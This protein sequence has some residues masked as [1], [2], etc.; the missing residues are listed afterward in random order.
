MKHHPEY[1][2]KAETWATDTQIL[3]LRS[4][5]TGWTVAA[6]AI[7][8][9]A[10]Q[11][12]ALAMLAPLK[13]VQP[14]TLLVDR[15]TGFVQAVDPDTPQRI[16]ADEA[17]TQSFLAQYVAA[18]EGF[19]RA[20]LALDYRKVALLSAGSAR[21]TYLSQMPATNPASPFRRFPSGAVVATRIK[22][23]SKLGP[24]TA[25]V[26]FDTQQQ[27]PSG[28]VLMPQPWIAVIRF[29]YSTA[30]MTLEDRLVNPLG[31]K[32]LTYR[33]NAEAP[34][35]EQAAPLRVPP[36]PGV[37]RPLGYVGQAAVNETPIAVPVGM[38]G[39]RVVELNRMPSGSPL[40]SGGQ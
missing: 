27:S 40:S 7:G 30:P 24:D 38:I 3:S 9:A 21:S 39:N 4:R 36:V 19:D 20:T 15:Q 16:A 25:I 35:P 12:L 5:R 17:L 32:A 22:S 18:R 2:D 11:A 10:L 6:V 37:A 26:R 29:A 34:P 1:F 8:I 28:G 33:R 14:I 13:T 23:V 31:F